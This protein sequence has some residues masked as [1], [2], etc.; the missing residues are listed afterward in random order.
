MIAELN[1]LR[2]RVLVLESH[3]ADRHAA[4]AH[5]LLSDAS[6]VLETSP[7]AI[8]GVDAEGPV[9]FF[10]RAAAET[11]GW[12]ADDALGRQASDVAHAAGR[13]ERRRKR[14]SGPKH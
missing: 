9:T 3:R 12:P 4:A 11:T 5:A 8:F 6:A 13:T 14:R 7:E 10:N 1:A 2:L